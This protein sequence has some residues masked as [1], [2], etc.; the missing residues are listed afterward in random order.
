MRCDAFVHYLELAVDDPT[1]KQLCIP[2]DLIEAMDCYVKSLD[3]AVHFTTAC[4][5]KDE[6]V[7]AQP[8]MPNG[9]RGRSRCSA[10]EDLV[11]YPTLLS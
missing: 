11:S 2:D 6:D 8:A 9:G 4:Q 5:S 7:A 10:G 1:D 3:E